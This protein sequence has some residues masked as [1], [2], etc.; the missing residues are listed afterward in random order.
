MQLRFAPF[1]LINSRRDLHPQECAR[2]GRTK[3]K[4]AAAAAGFQDCL[5]VLVTHAT[6]L[7][8]RVQGV[9]LEARITHVL[10]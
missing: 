7:R 1:A 8:G 2:A 9:A 3:K 5:A 4:P 6:G 10:D